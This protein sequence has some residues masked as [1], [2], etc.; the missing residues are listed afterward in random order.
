[1]MPTR[2]RNDTFTAKSIGFAD[3]MIFNILIIVLIYAVAVLGSQL[4]LL[5]DRGVWVGSAC[6]LHAA[7][8][9]TRSCFTYL[10][11]RDG[12]GG[13]VRYAATEIDASLALWSLVVVLA[14][15]KRAVAFLSGGLGRSDAPPSFKPAIA[16]KP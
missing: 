10:S 11:V 4:M 5:H 14:A 15:L 13:V 2:T 8:T 7:I 16:L 6:D 12:L 1:M 3:A 9:G